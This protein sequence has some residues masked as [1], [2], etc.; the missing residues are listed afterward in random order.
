MNL[1]D[2]LLVLSYHNSLFYF[3][4]NERSS[5][6]RNSKAKPVACV[7]TSTGLKT[8]SPSQVSTRKKA[9]KCV[10]FQIL[11]RIPLTG[12]L[13]SPKFYGEMWKVNDNEDKCTE[14][15]S[16]TSEKCEDEVCDACLC[17]FNAP[18]L[19]CFKSDRQSRPAEKTLQ[20]NPARVPHPRL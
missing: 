20:G 18:L 14:I 12:M 4:L 11:K 13:I 17:S 2:L 10:D 7:A 5:W 19:P 8:S 3:C 6:I 1:P 15:R 9:N 16:V